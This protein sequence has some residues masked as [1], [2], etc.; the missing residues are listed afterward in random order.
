MIEHMIWFEQL[1]ETTR[2]AA[3]ALASGAGRI[4][5]TH[6]MIVPRS[7]RPLQP[8]VSTLAMMQ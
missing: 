6:D 7:H 8:S 1:R 3:K 4:N 2:L 5:V